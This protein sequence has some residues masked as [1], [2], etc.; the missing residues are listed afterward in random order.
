MQVLNDSAIHTAADAAPSELQ[1][2]ATSTGTLPGATGIDQ[3]IVE[4]HARY[5]GDQRG[6]LADYIPALAAAD[7]TL[8]ALCLADVGGGIHSAGD[9][10]VEFSIQSISKAFLFALVDQHLGHDTVRQAVGV[11]NTGLPFNSVVAIE[12]NAGSPMNPM[13]N[14]GALSTTGLVPG[15][16]ADARWEFIRAGLSSFAGRELVLDENVYRSEAAT[17]GRNRAIARLLQSYDTLAAD[18]DETVDLYTR[19]CSLNVTAH[20]LAVMGA[21]LA[22]GGVNPVTEDRVVDAAV[23]RDTLAA[24]AA[25]GFYER[26]GDWLYEIGMP[27][28]SGVSGGIV[29]ISPG[30]GALGS[31]SPLLDPAGTS[32]RGQRAAHFLSGALGLNLF[33][34]APS[35]MRAP[36]DARL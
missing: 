4:T 22:D 17:N 24:L 25:S 12:L 19:Q 34:S 32:V 1:Q 28:K 35:A 5:L 20:D 3:L 8:F 33:A 14:A 18:P 2:A 9:T 36:V 26:S 11:N 16:N 7:P 23:C 31:Y 10:L 21:T 30:K 29:T 13:V 6:A 27:G 15:A